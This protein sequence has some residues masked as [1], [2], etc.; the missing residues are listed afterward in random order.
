MRKRKAFTLV[1]LLVVI[2]IINV[3]IAML[4]HALNKA[5]EAANTVAC[6][7]N[8]KQ[9]GNTFF[10]YAQDNHGA[11]VPALS[12]APQYWN[13]I[14]SGRIW[15]E[16]ICRF[17]PYSATPNYGLVPDS[18]RCPA[19][20]EGDP[21]RVKKREY[22]VNAWICGTASTADLYDIHKFVRLTA[23][24]QE[25][26]LVMDNGLSTKYSIPYSVWIGF[27]H[28]NLCNVLYADGHVSARGK[29]ELVVTNSLPLHVGE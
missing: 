16:F 27:P 5:R 8:L 26:M 10:M 15:P 19:I 9:I 23:P 28:N 29:K 7:S 12:P 22:A 13:G 17:G 21:L 11:I 2:G 14:V 3:L 6:A 18:F 20:Q 1:E 4:L 24:S 25:V